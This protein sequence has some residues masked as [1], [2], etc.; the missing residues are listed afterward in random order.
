MNLEISFL[1]YL[2]NCIFL[3]IKT[4]KKIFCNTLLKNKLLRFSNLKF[5]F[6]INRDHFQLFIVLNFSSTFN[7]CELAVVMDYVGKLMRGN[8]IFNPENIGIVT[9]FKL[10]EKK[11]KDEL[12]KME[13][14]DR[15]NV[16]TVQLFQGQEREV[17]IVTTVRSRLLEH[18]GKVHIGFLDNEKVGSLLGK[19]NFFN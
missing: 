10:Q 19:Y 3:S 6:T 17:I 4:T 8:T 2:V 18:E 11:I 7:L 9:P 12:K 5:L 16:G 13:L 15:I 14:L 1:Y